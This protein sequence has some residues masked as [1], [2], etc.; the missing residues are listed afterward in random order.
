MGKV[1]S[2]EKMDR[3]INE[4]INASFAFDKC[5]VNEMEQYFNNKKNLPSFY[6][7]EK[8]EE[9]KTYLDNNLKINNLKDKNE[10]N[11]ETIVNTL[12]STFI[13][14]PKRVSI[15]YHRGDITDEELKEQENE[16]DANYYLNQEILNQR[17][18]DI[19]YLENLPNKKNFNL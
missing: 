4:A 5:L 15:L 3:L 2:P 17:T 8:F 9:L 7:E 12:K 14:K 13:D 6:A 18:K 19:K 1:Y 10:L 11:Y 16:L